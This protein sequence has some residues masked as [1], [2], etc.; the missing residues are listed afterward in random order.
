MNRRRFLRGTGA[1]GALTLAGC[2]ADDDNDTESG[3]DG[4]PTTDG[5]G[6]ETPAIVGS[7]IQRTGSQCAGHEG[8]EGTQ[9][10]ETEYARTSTDESTLTVSLTGQLITS[11]PCYKP[12]ISETDYD[13]GADRLTVT[14]GAEAE[15]KVCMDCVGVVEFAGTVEFDGGVPSDVVVVHD[16]VTLTPGGGESAQP[17]ADRPA[18][19]EAPTLQAGSFAVTDVSSSSPAQSANPSFNEDEGTVVV[20]GTIIG[21]NGCT[22]ADIGSADYDASADQLDV[23]VVTE[24]REGDE[25]SFCTQQMVGIDYEATFSFSGGIPSKVSVSHDGEG[26]GSAAYGSSSADAPDSE[27]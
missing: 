22:T 10:P 6:N 11:T 3:G 27:N 20:T 14:L 4:T 9:T 23:N 18:S 24:T 13:A 15:D 5:A 2:I 7:A 1:L 26:V 21:N 16:G 25:D 17:T 8:E 19:G 12:T